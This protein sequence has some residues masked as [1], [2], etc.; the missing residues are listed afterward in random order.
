MGQFEKKKRNCES[1]RFFSIELERRPNMGLSKWMRTAISV[2]HSPS[3][4]SNVGGEN[5]AGPSVRDEEED[6]YV[7]S[8]YN[9]DDDD[10]SDHDRGEVNVGGE[11]VYHGVHL[12][13]EDR[14]EIHESS[15][16]SSEDDMVYSGDDVDLHR[17]SEEDEEGPEFPMFNTNEIYD[18]PFSIGLQFS[19]KAEFRKAVN[20]HA[21]KIRITLKTTRNDN[22]RV[23]RFKS[24]PRRNV[25]G[26]RED[27]INEINC[28]VSK[29]QAYRAKRKVLKMIEGDPDVQYT[30]LWDYC[31]ELRKTNP[32]FT[33]I[34]GT[35]EQ[36]GEDLNIVRQNEYT[37]MSDKQKGLIVPFKRGL[38]FS[39]ALWRAAYATTVGEY[40]MRMQ[41]LMDLDSAAIE[42]FKDKSP[43]QW[44]KSHFSEYSKCDMLL[45]NVYLSAMSCTC[46]KWG[47]SGIPGAHALS[48]IFDQKQDPKDYVH[49]YYSV[50]T[51]KRVY[52]P[53]IMGING[54][55]IWGETLFIPQLPPNFGREAGRPTSARRRGAEEPVRKRKKRSMGQTQKLRRQQTTVQCGKC[56]VEGHNAGT[57]DLDDEE[58]KRKMHLTIKPRT[59]N[60]RGGDNEVH[61]DS[62]IND[63]EVVPPVVET[64]TQEQDGGCSN[65]IGKVS[66]RVRNESRGKG[67]GTAIVG[68]E[69]EMQ[70][71]TFNNDIEQGS[72]R[73]AFRPPRSIKPPSNLQ[74]AIGIPAK[75]PI[76]QD[77]SQQP[78]MLP[79]LSTTEET[80]AKDQVETIIE[81]QVRTKVG[82]YPPLPTIATLN[83]KSVESFKGANLIT[84]SA[85]SFKGANLITKSAESFK[86]A[87]QGTST[88]G[89]LRPRG[90]NSR[91]L[92]NST[93]TL[94]E[95]A[96]IGIG[97]HQELKVDLV[98]YKSPSI[99]REKDEREKEGEKRKKRE[100][101]ETNLRGGDTR[102]F[103]YKVKTIGRRASLPGTGGSRRSAGK[104][105]TSFRGIG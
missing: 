62:G 30:K 41:Q 36:G 97:T 7:D 55:L 72:E 43:L 104:R 60:D 95:A 100:E 76:A 24:D 98:L 47:L 96:D 16:S 21:I 42:W 27:V 99:A 89:W 32:G 87:N 71:M 92:W 5:E 86:G 65:D 83:T 49:S 84:K 2:G 53:A 31:E 10:V 102:P 58:G 4:K 81:T 35:E 105:R 52:E 75:Q 103:A 61:V 66:R 94:N 1:H 29:D 28:G 11:N 101:E 67:K 46:R 80:E 8:D 79:P 37:F 40:K 70:P 33:V 13:G 74:S 82:V 39:N 73:S 54:A 3:D 50:A 93:L 12:G 85:E 14:G 25:F 15:D 63:N 20:S 56:G 9:P 51:Y 91:R 23:Y 88:N 45:N 38:A 48:A 44:S 26:F 77:A 90:P 69:T 34:L 68:N 78:V 59:S 64:P 17:L 22:M 19:T 57:C 6:A 18:P